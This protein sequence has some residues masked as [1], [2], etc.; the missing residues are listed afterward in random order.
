MEQVQL[1]RLTPTGPPLEENGNSALGLKCTSEIEVEFRVTAS[2][3]LTGCDVTKRKISA[4]GSR[5]VGLIGM[6][7]ETGMIAAK[8][9]NIRFDPISIVVHIILCPPRKFCDAQF[10]IESG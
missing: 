6:I 3:F 2:D 1:E 9:V 8:Q 4:V 10:Q 7:H 5:C